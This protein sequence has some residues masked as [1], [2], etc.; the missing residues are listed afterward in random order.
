M[1]DGLQILWPMKLNLRSRRRALRISQ[2]R[3]ARLAGV[4]R[5]KICIYELGDGSLTSDEHGIVISKTFGGW[6]LIEEERRKHGDNAVR[7]GIISCDRRPLCWEPP[8]QK[9]P[10]SPVEGAR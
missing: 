4:S 8:K 10:Q 6:A 2:L 3:L 1:R 7:R 9:S 5:F